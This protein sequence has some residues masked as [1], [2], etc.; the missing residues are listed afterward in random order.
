MAHKEV[1]EKG[2][3]GQVLEE[4]GREEVSCI[5]QPLLSSA[6]LLPSSSLGRTSFP[7]AYPHYGHGRHAR[8]YPLSD[9]RA[10]VAVRV[11]DARVCHSESACMSFQL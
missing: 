6:A 1:R 4:E 8:A 5:L 3:E 2:G 9:D 10:L 11:C 7:R